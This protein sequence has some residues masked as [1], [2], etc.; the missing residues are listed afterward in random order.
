LS[1]Y[2]ADF[3][4]KNHYLEELISAQA[5]LLRHGK[6]G[7]YYGR[8]FKG[9]NLDRTFSGTFRTKFRYAFS[10]TFRMNFYRKL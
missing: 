6:Y 4:I 9:K 3:F 8:D 1:K 5:L 10:Y 7:G 2:R